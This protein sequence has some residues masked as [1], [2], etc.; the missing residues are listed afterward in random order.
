MSEVKAKVIYTNTRKISISLYP[1]FDMGCLLSEIHI[2]EK[3]GGD[4]AMGSC[5]LE[6]AGNDK[7]LEA[8]TKQYKGEITI[9]KEGGFSLKIPIFIISKNWYLNNLSLN[10]ICIKDES[11]IRDLRTIDYPDLGS[12]ISNCY[13][14]EKDIRCGTDVKSGD[15]KLYQTNETD[16]SFLTR[17]LR[18]YKKNSIF[19]FTWEG[20]LLIK[21]VPGIDSLGNKE[22]H[23]ILTNNMGISMKD[24]FKIVY[25]P[26]NYRKPE[27][28]WEPEKDPK[29]WAEKQSTLFSVTKFGGLLKLV[30]KE[31][32]S[33]NNNIAENS[34]FYDPDLFTSFR[35]VSSTLFPIKLGDVIKF[36]S[37]EQKGKRP[38]DSF[39]VMSNEFYMSR[40]GS[41]HHDENGLN[42]SV[43]TKL[44]G[45]QENG[46]TLPIEDPTK[47]NK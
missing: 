20:K 41:Q 44:I 18:G 6:I 47:E 45:I 14:G 5:S 40:D 23:T 27:N 25:N 22:P 21:E 43:T 1:W 39:L 35:T 42:F 36:R 12:A 8:I 19:G 15:Y 7:L 38:F 33:L 4:L 30:G 16:H 10:F 17:H 13:K 2:Y 24:M 34:R 11:F 9:E 28:P 29:K 3:I 46:S 37:P 32:Q 26:K 31:L